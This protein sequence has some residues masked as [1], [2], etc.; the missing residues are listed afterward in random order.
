MTFP[1]GGARG[2]NSLDAAAG[3]VIGTARTAMDPRMLCRPPPLTKDEKADARKMPDANVC[4]FCLGL[5]KF[6]S[7]PG[8][9]RLATF[10]LNGDGDVIEGT[11]W[12][13]TKWAKGRVV[14][15]EDTHEDE[16]EDEDE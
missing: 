11:F 16:E 1:P 14:L 5:H 7:G 13:G 9:P 12:P 8:C 3:Q 2:H 6:P 15:I 10:K 4:A